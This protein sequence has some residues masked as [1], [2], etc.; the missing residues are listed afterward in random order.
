MSKKI[1]EQMILRIH[2]KCCTIL[3]HEI[4]LDSHQ[5]KALLRMEIAAFL[6][7]V[8]WKILL[9]LFVAVVGGI[10][11]QIMKKKYLSTTAS[12][13]K[14][15]VMDKIGKEIIVISPEQNE[16]CIIMIHEAL[17][18]FGTS[19]KQ[20]RRIFDL[21]LKETQEELKTG[22]DKGKLLLK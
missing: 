18:P 12:E 4:F 13:V 5:P 11:V 9:P 17:K 16:E 14:A 19:R 21:L 22:K 3:S 8:A 7:A 20:A 15:E 10:S 1:T 6:D 2:S